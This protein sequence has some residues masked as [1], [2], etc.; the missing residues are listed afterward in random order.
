MKRAA[1]LLCAMAASLTVDARGT[2][3]T[4]HTS[5]FD[6]STEISVEPHGADCGFNMAGVLV[7]A[8][9]ST[10]WESTVMLSV[11]TINHYA[12]IE[13]AALNIDGQLV[14]LEKEG[15]TQHEQIGVVEES[16]ARFKTDLAT[17]RAL[18]AAPRSMIRL[19]TD[20]GYQDCHIRKA[21]KP[22]GSLAYDALARFAAA[23]PVAA[24]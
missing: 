5:D 10:A 4:T 9:W 21:E 6:G 15:I 19:T 13:R 2:R 3:V 24:P 17:V 18:V 8:T 1:L 11:G 20:K 16:T 14:Q 23:L 7:G 22:K 12:I